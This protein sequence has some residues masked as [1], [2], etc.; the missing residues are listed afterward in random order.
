MK[1][2]APFTLIELL[3]VIAII[4]ILAS[5]LLPALQQ[6]RER[7]QITSCLNNLKSCGIYALQYVEEN[8]GCAPGG[9]HV[10]NTPYSGFATEGLGSWFNLLAPYAGFEK[11]GF[12]RI[13]T[14]KG[15]LVPQTKPCVFSCTGKK[16][17]DITAYGAKI[18]FSIVLNSAGP[19]DYG[20]SGYK[21]LNWL[22]MRTPAKRAWHVDTR[23]KVNSPMVSNM[24][25]GT[26]YDGL[27]FPHF[28][29]A[30]TPVNHM[31]GHVAV[32]PSVQ[33]G[34]MHSSKTTYPYK[35]GLFYYY[36]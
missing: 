25:P 27:N 21:N 17:K 26:N 34:Q 31:D 2:H 3:V 13:S 32:Y 10:S 28:N 1:K 24:N 5:R 35:Y 33:L 19:Y 7:G 18:D 20:P 6:A 15:K 30:K 12:Y 16:A 4:A 8:R 14:V 22:K 23:S 11:F 29:G 9:R 36:Y